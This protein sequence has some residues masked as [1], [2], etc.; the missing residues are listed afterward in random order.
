VCSMKNTHDSPIR[1]VTG[2]RWAGLAAAR[3]ACSVLIELEPHRACGDDDP[4]FCV[5]SSRRRRVSV[6]LRWTLYGSSAPLVSLDPD[7]ALLHAHS[8]Y[9]THAHTH[10]D[11]SEVIN[12]Y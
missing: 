10:S 1:Q 12:S 2:V 5:S 8:E 3:A 6:I 4:L 9:N 11:K 7:S